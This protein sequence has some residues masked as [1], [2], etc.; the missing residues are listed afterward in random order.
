MNLRAIEES[1]ARHFSYAFY[2]VLLGYSSLRAVAVGI[3]AKANDKLSV[4]A[5]LHWGCFYDAGR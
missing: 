2:H 1:E 3:P 4:D 5:R